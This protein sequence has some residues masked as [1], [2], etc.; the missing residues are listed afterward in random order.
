MID[1]KIVEI[2]VKDKDQYG[3]V[4][5]EVYYN[6]KNIN[7][8]MLET[9]NAWWYKQYSKGNLEFAAAEE[10]AKLEGLGLWKEKSPTPPWEFRRKNNING[11]LILL[12]LEIERL[13]RKFSKE[14]DEKLKK[15]DFKI[16]DVTFDKKDDEVLKIKITKN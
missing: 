7:L 11:G 2:D 15:Y 4:V 13:I 8:Y 1:G 3:R 9:G 16:K 10:K 14:I 5:G 12:N 6:G